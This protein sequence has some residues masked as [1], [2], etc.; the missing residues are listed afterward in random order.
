[1]AAITIADELSEANRRIAELEVE[2]IDLKS[3]RD[4]ADK[5]AGRMG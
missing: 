2:I 3:D 5:R 1:M 4:D